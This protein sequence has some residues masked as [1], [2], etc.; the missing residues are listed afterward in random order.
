VGHLRRDLTE[1]CNLLIVGQ[2][3]LR[4]YEPFLLP[5]D[6]SKQDADHDQV[7]RHRNEEVLTALLNLVSV[8]GI[9]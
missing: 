8:F 3:F 9:F 5:V 6:Q 7:D 2:V 1:G 4:I